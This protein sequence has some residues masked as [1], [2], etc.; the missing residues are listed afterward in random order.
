MEIE[1]QNFE[2]TI[3]EA[4]NALIFNRKQLLNKLTSLQQESWSILKSIKQRPIVPIDGECFMQPQQWYPMIISYWIRTLLGLSNGYKDVSQIIGQ[5]G[6]NH[7]FTFLK[8]DY[9]VV[10]RIN[11][12]NNISIAR[13]TDTKTKQQ[14]GDMMI[15]PRTKHPHGCGDVEDVKKSFDE[16]INILNNLQ[17]PSICRKIDAG[18]DIHNLYYVINTPYLQSLPELLAEMKKRNI[19]Y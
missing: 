16:T 2:N 3:N 10:K 9:F 4:M 18:M 13:I 14:F 7:K 15:I 17:Y 1:K 19:M 6:K 11:A 12:W 8:Q 5:F